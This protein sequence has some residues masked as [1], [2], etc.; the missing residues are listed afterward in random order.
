MLRCPTREALRPAG[1]RQNIR[2][3]SRLRPRFRHWCQ[4]RHLR[5]S[6]LYRA[7]GDGLFRDG[8]YLRLGGIL[9]IRHRLDVG[10]VVALVSYLVRFYGPLAGLSNIQVSIMTA[11]V[12]F[13]RVFEVLD[14]PP[15]I[16]EKP[17]AISIPNRPAQISFELPDGAGSLARIP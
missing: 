2:S 7:N 13:E 4:A 15:M 12:S 3:E 14:L 6:F 16:Q 17:R 5:S 9:A 11:L 8:I 10:T 1:R